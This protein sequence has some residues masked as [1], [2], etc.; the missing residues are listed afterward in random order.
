MSGCER[1]L[2]EWYFYV[3]LIP[4]SFL[5]FSAMKLFVYLR[6][7]SS[8]LNNLLKKIRSAAKKFVAMRYICDFYYNLW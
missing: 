1:R 4:R 2:L 3:P 6:I 7:P 5:A 8:T